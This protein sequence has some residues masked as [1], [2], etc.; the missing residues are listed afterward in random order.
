VLALLYQ[1]TALVVIPL[2]AG[3]GSSV[4]TVEALGAGKPVFGTSTAFRGLSLHPGV[5]CVLQDDLAQWPAQIAELLAAPTRLAAIA[6][7]ARRAGEAYDYRGVFDAYLPLMGLPP[8]SPTAAA[9]P[10]RNAMLGDLLAR[11][12][13]RETPEVAAMLLT[14]SDLPRDAVDLATLRQLLAAALRHNH[15]PVALIAADR[16]E[17]LGRPP[18]PA[19]LRDL[20]L[21]ATDAGRYDLAESFLQRLDDRQTTSPRAQALRQLGRAMELG[22]FEQA[23][24]LLRRLECDAEPVRATSA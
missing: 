7:A 4:K 22:E 14:S 19:V 15:L 8:A 17:A 11:A 21:R 2:Q 24:A 9:S 10:T 3:T 6:A 18:E 23:R 1:L 20:V 16:L 12:L 13:A 5:D